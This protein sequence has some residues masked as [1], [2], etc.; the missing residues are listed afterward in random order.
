MK[1]VTKMVDILNTSK[2]TI[3]S[4]PNKIKAARIEKGLSQQDMADLMGWSRYHF[5][6]KENN[7][8]EPTLEE[9]KAIAEKLDK[10]I[11]ELFFLTIG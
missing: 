7:L 8:K 1:G 2:V 4:K 3:K 6:K 5:L 9:A 10:P 11:D